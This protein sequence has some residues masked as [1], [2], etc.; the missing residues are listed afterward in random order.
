MKNILY[1]NTQPS[2]GGA[3]A[4]MQRL[5]DMVRRQ[6]MASAIL[7][8]APAFGQA[9]DLK[10]AKYTG[11]H[12]WTTWRG[13]QDYGFQKIMRS[14]APRFFSKRTLYTCTTCTAATSTSGPCL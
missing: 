1:I 13:Q 11:L 10:A 8:G 5:A 7:T 9:P 3:A 12:A 2:G 14:S 4:V 6:G